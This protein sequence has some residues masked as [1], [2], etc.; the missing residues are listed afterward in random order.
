MELNDKRKEIMYK[1]TDF[2]NHL[3][4]QLQNIFKCSKC[5]R[6]NTIV[7]PP[8]ILSQ[9]CLFCGNPNYVKREKYKKYI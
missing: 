9:S 4:C 1:K 3:I 8:N 6:N 2:N 5:K 7:V